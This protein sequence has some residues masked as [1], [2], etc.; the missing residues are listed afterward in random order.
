MNNL[1]NISLLE[2]FHIIKASECLAKAFL[3][4]PM[5][6]TLKISYNM[7]RE[8][9]LKVVSKAAKESKL[10]VVAIGPLNEQ[11]VG[12]CINK[13]LLD[14]PIN[15]DDLVNKKFYPIFELLDELDNRYRK[16]NKINP[17]EMFHTLMI[18]VDSNSKSKN[19]SSSLLE[20]SFEIAKK[21]GYKKAIM[22]ATGPISQHI[23]INKFGYK[24]F[25]SIKYSDYQFKNN[26]VFKH[27]TNAPSCKLLTKELV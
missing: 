1:L 16:E 22:E 9:C 5:A 3:K 15:E 19:I 6:E 18:A 14:P 12:V 24:E 13:D 10:S 20:A 27:I 4:E 21:R 2:D 25:T 26:Y 8:F 23:A 7:M 11:I 17:N